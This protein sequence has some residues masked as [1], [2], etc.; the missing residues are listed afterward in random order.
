MPTLVVDSALY[1]ANTVRELSDV[2][3]VT[4]VPATIIE[5]KIRLAEIDNPAQR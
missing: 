4:R 2:S 3:W 5:A 1:S